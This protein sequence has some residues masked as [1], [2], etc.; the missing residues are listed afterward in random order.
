[1]QSKAKFKS[2]N[3]QEIKKTG[4]TRRHWRDAGAEC[5]VATWERQIEKEKTARPAPKPRPRP[6][7]VVF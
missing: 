4:D 5:W 3:K 1:M 7:Y 6:A 2:K